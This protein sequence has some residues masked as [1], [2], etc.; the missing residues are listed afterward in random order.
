MDKREQRKR[1]KAVRNGISAQERSGAQCAIA[2][3]AVSLPE[4]IKCDIL[5][6]YVSFGSEVS[7]LDIIKRAWDMGK[8][9]AVPLVTEESNMCF[10]YISSAEELKE[11][12]YGIPEP[13][14]DREKLALPTESSLMLLPGLA[15]DMCFYRL[16]YGGGYY[17]RYLARYPYVIKAGI[18]FEAQLAAESLPRDK[19]DIPTDIIITENKVL[20]RSLKI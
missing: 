13:E 9:V 8:R 10:M 2:E 18:C 11:G 1:Y 12:S 16:G 15:F 4:F 6:S 3:R 17:D 20:K 5:F 14:Y 7:T 19:N